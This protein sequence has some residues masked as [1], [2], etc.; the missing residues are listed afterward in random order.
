MGVDAARWAARQSRPEL[1]VIYGRDMDVSGSLESLIHLSITGTPSVLAE[2]VE[3]YHNVLWNQENLKVAR[4]RHH[5]AD[6][7]KGVTDDYFV[8]V[9]EP[10]RQI[11]DGRDR[12]ATVDPERRMRIDE[13]PSQ[14]PHGSSESAQSAPVSMGELSDYLGK[15]FGVFGSGK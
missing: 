13:E 3:V 2:D 4:L 1:V 5:L 8:R 14:R 9:G 11:F 7:K 10:L 12:T 15:Y 6:R